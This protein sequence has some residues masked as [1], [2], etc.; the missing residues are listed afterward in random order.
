MIFIRADAN[1]KIGTG[2]VMRCL[3]IASAFSVAGED[4]YFV[5]ADHRGDILINCA[6]FRALCLGSCWTVMEGE[7]PRLLEMIREYKP[8]ILLVDSYYV[9]ESYFQ[10]LSGEVRVAYID[11]MNLASWNIDYLINYN[12]FADVFN[13][14][15]YDRTKTKLLLNPQYAPLREE[16]R[17]LPRHEV[18]ENITDILVSAGGADP[19]GI[20]ERLIRDVCP[21]EPDI[22]F[23][24]I[25]G[26][27]NPRID[28][29]KKLECRNIIL[30]INEQHMSALMIQC[31]VAISAAGTTLYELCAAGIP[32]ITYILADNQIVATEQFESRQIMLSAGDCRKNNDFIN[33]VE[34]CLLRLKSD[35]ALRTELSQKMQKLVDGNGAKRIVDNIM[36]C[37]IHKQVSN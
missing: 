8:Q 35:K 3:S 10:K 36:L 26:A 13:Y 5:T 29:I 4:V 28:D 17:C 34:L 22:N 37:N 23:H 14:S 12:I 33:R 24:F 1:E 19:E 27:L 11:D 31:D 15:G 16:F 6:G 25:I 9:T 7:V 32:T 30:H 2:H 20:S 21:R 18:K